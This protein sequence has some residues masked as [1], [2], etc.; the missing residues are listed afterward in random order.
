MKNLYVPLSHSVA[1]AI[2]EMIFLQK[3]FLPGDRIP[4]E[5]QLAKEIGVSRTSIREAVRLLIAKGVLEIQRGKGTFVTAAPDVTDG[6]LG[7][8]MIEDHRLLV[9]DWFEFRLILEPGAVRMATMQATA[10]ELD[11]IEHYEQLAAAHLGDNQVFDVADAQLHIAIAKATHNRVI[12]RLVPFLQDSL[13]EARRRSR[14]MHTITPDPVAK[15]AVVTHRQIIHYMRLGDAEG[16]SVAM[17]YHI[18]RAMLDLE[19]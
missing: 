17:A 11:T 15:N 1:N 5:V 7:I 10:E 19:L 16:A 3:R 18:K 13:A 6:L 12:E 2:T 8:P 9:R 4:S 14:Y